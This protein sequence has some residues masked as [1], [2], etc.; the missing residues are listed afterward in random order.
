MFNVDISDINLNEHIKDAI[1]II[2]DSLQWISVKY[3]ELRDHIIDIP[4]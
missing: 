2:G 4:R 1:H 3:R